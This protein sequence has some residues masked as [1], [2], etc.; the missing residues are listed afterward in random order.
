MSKVKILDCTLRDGGYINGWDFG[1]R[2]I[3]KVISKLAKAKIDIIECGFLE[4]RDFDSN[5]ALY[6]SVERIRDYIEPKSENVM[7][8]GMIA[9]PY[10]SIDKISPCDGTSIDGIRV[11]FHENEIEEAFIYGKQLMDRGYQVFIQP[12]GTTSYSDSALLDLIEKVNALK[13]YAFY[14]VDTLGIMYKNDLLR[15]FHLLDNNLD[16]GVSVGFHSHNNLQLSFSN[17]Q[18]ILSLHTKRNIIIDASVMGMGRG[19]GN[20]CTEL[21]THYINEN[22]NEKYDTIPLLEIVDEHLLAIF[23]EN[24]WGYSIPYYLA[25]VNGCHPNYTSNL[26]NKQTISVKSINAIL[27]QIPRRNRDIYDKELIE[28]LYI[29][30]QSHY[31]NDIEELMVIGELVRNRKILVI[32]PGKSIELQREEI[33]DF[34]M[35][36]NP[37]VFSVNFVPDTFTTDTVFISNQKRFNLLSD[38]YDGQF[39]NT[40]FITTSNIKAANGFTS[41]V[42]N[43]TDLLVDNPI[44]SDNAGLLLLNLLHRVS[45]KEVYVAGFDGFSIDKANNYFSNELNNNTELNELIKKNE[46]MSQFLSFLDKKMSIHFITSTVYNEMHKDVITN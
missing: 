6:N 12:V 28:Q 19:A 22:I 29:D 44:I 42:V 16:S 15:M 7:Y 36:N 1:E 39:E 9:Q 4:E 40:A 13:P 10:I 18:E 35:I 27:R 31:V 37:I 25:A 32:A 26:I 14:L 20:L 8:V 38:G 30:Y 5:K 46:A 45:A 24:N 33:Q 43:Y 11:T 34:I 23:N 2:T 17:A 21:I 41:I 3:K